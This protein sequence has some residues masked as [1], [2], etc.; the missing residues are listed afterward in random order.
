M[1]DGDNAYKLPTQPVEMEES[2]YIPASI[3]PSTPPS[4]PAY[5]YTF[6]PVSVPVELDSQPLQRM[7]FPSNE[8]KPH[9]VGEDTS[10][11]WGQENG[12][13][14]KLQADE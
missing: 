8:Y 11:T 2:T 5:T 13:G 12:K 10:S 14:D 9:T 4:T 7:S 3:P 1:R 6:I